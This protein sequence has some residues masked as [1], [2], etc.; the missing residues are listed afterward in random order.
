MYE[1][2][3]WNFFKKEGILVV[4]T[5]EVSVKTIDTSLLPNKNDSA[6]GTTVQ[7][8]EDG[9]LCVVLMKDVIHPSSGISSN[10]DI[11]ISDEDKVQEEPYDEVNQN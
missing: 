10:D 6:T 7:F 1:S 8:L 5:T 3:G 9:G 2:R 11:S 4:E